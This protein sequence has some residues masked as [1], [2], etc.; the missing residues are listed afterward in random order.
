[1]KTVL[2]KNLINDQN[3]HKR[4]HLRVISHANFITLVKKKPI[5]FLYFDAKA[6]VLYTLTLTDLFLLYI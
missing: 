4:Y 6:V 3:R 1:M 2:I 5:F